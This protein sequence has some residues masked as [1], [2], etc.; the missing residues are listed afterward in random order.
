[1]K[2]YMKGFIALAVA[3]ICTPGTSK[4]AAAPAAGFWRIQG[5]AVADG[6]GHPVQM[7]GVNLGNWLLWEGWMF[8]PRFARGSETL[9]LN[10]LS[11]AESG[12]DRRFLEND[13]DLY[14]TERDVA[15][16][17]QAG[18]NLIRV[19]VNWKSLAHDP[20]C[21]ACDGKGF[22]HLDQLIGWARRYGIHVIIDMHAVP[23]GQ[24]R[25]PTADPPAGG[26]QFWSHPEDQARL[27]EL[28]TAVA[29][30][31]ARS[32]V[33][34]GYDLINEP[35]APSDDALRRVYRNLIS[36]IRSVD[37]DHTIWLEGN[38][39][40]IDLAVFTE[41][42][43]ANVGYS[44]HVYIVGK[45]RRSEELAA[46]SAAAHR[47]DAPVWIGEFGQ[48]SYEDTRSTVQMMKAADGV[49]GWAYWTWKRAASETPT[50]CGLQAPSAWT[51][52]SPWIVGGL[53]ANKPK[54]DAVIKGA[55]AYLA[56]LSH[57]PCTPDPKMV[58]ALAP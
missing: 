33:V 55:D 16:M 25:A 41:P 27:T 47:L 48:S 50:V 17:K 45:D 52:I 51:A 46:A 42:M 44:S 29:K 39:F 9:M 38:F 14:V 32:P 43:G 36:A 19:P 49:A 28:W 22:A 26:P 21:P 30:R 34:A 6:D 35:N 58:Q 56:Y 40:A 37:P 1:M 10:R 23:G 53:G 31:Y 20:D 57:A 2:A 5:E 54:P 4:A 15:A 18:F 3:T 24:T 13:Q 7:R 12:L 11:Q 8:D